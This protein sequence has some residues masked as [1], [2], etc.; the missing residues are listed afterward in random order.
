MITHASCTGG[1]FRKYHPQHVQHPGAAQL[2]SASEPDVTVV[3]DADMIFERTN[4]NQSSLELRYLLYTS[5]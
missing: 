5:Q 2:A 1:A 4:F 3:A